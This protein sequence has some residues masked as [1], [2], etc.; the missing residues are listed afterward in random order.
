MTRANL[1]LQKNMFP[2]QVCLYSYLA[3]MVLTRICNFQS[4]PTPKHAK[5]AS[6]APPDDDDDFIDPTSTTTLAIQPLLEQEAL[7]ETFV[8]EAKAQRKFEDAKTLRVNLGEIRQEIE[9][10]LAAEGLKGKRARRGR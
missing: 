9:R 2:L 8:E 5:A 1:F 3:F 7:L 4:L 10:V 6:S